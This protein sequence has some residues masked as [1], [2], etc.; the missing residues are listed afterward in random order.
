MKRWITCLVFV[1]A[2]GMQPLAA[3]DSGNGF[4][5]T[6]PGAQPGNVLNKPDPNAPYPKP[7]GTGV[8]YMMSEHGLQ[9]INPAA[10][11]HL[12][13]GEKTLTQNI[14]REGRQGDENEDRKPF[15]GIVL[16]GLSF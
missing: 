5:A 8:I 12:G 9:V 6:Q 1:A 15:G 13:K 14:A 10:P 16:V 3:Q 2:A 11:A 4:S 7:K